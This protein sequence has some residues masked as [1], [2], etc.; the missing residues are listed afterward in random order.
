MLKIKK[1]IILKYYK[2]K[3]ITIKH[4]F[5]LRFLPIKYF[6]Y[7]L[8]VFIKNEIAQIIK[9]NQIK[10][11]TSFIKQLSKENSYYR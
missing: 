8:F 6:V 3:Y 1:I 10:S 7:D 11:N 9:S 5:L 2:Y 4:F